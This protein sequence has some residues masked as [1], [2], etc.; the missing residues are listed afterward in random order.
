M[1]G[2]ESSAPIPSIEQRLLAIHHIVHDY[3]NFVSSAEMVKSGRHLGKGFDSPINHHIFH[4]FLLNCRKLRDFFTGLDG[5]DVV[6][7]H[8][9]STVVLILP[10][11]EKWRIPIDR[12]LAHL[13]YARIADSKPIEQETNIALYAELKGA[14]KLFLSHLPESYRSQFDNELVNK[15]KLSEFNGLD[16]R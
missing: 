13:S 14:W 10:I 4:A 15:E 11:S 5:R 1:P 8:F 6:A 3:A 16:L 9:V 7:G 12:Q 2:K